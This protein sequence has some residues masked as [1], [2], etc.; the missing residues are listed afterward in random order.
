MVLAPVR[1]KEP[2]H[3][4]AAAIM[5]HALVQILLGVIGL[6]VA[7]S[8]EG[9][10]KQLAQYGRSLKGIPP[11]RAPVELGGLRPPADPPPIDP[12]ASTQSELSMEDPALTTAD[13]IKIEALRLLEHE[14]AKKGD[15]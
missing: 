1:M 9:F 7:K 8:F 12:M 3:V 11:T 15:R 14:R 4:V 6:Q 2:L 10:G 5:F 13:A